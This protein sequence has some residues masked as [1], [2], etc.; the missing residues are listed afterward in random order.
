M[1]NIEVLSIVIALSFGVFSI[2][3]VLLTLF[4]WNRG[5]SHSGRGH[6]DDNIESIRNDLD[7]I[8]GR[9]NKMERRK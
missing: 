2:V 9:L 8:Y 7:E 6:R 5:E 3:G 4:L 1:T